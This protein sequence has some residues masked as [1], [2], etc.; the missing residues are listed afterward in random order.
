MI[1]YSSHDIVG[2]FTVG[3]PEGVPGV[4]PG[5]TH[6]PEHTPERKTSSTGRVFKGCFWVPKFHLEPPPEHPSERLL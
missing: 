2:G 3:V 4:V 6:P 5:G 1:E